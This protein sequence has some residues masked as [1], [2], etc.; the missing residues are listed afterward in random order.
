MDVVARSGFCFFAFFRKKKMEA[1]RA[2]LKKAQNAA[3]VPTLDV[4]IQ[5]CECVITRSEGS[6]AE[7][8]AERVA[9]EEFTEARARLQRL[10]SEMIAETPS[11]TR[12]ETEVKTRQQVPELQCQKQLL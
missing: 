12:L 3:S 5:Q 2:E 6:S 9:E 1:F 11:A 7:V 8:D 10:R 4:Q